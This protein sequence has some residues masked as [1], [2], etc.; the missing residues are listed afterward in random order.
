MEKARHFDFIVKGRTTPIVRSGSPRSPSS[1]LAVVCVVAVR[2]PLTRVFGVEEDGQALLGQRD[3]GVLALPGYADL[4]GVWL[5]PRPEPSRLADGSSSRSWCSITVRVQA[6]GGHHQQHRRHGAAHADVAGE[7]R[8]GR[9]ATASKAGPGC[10]CARDGS[11]RHRP[12]PRSAGRPRGPLAR[13]RDPP[14]VS[15]P[16]SANRCKASRTAP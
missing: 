6:S 3:R 11:A 5:V 2:H 7:R 15:E 12:T 14:P 13:P 8:G 1:R 9:G 10:R 4:V 16:S